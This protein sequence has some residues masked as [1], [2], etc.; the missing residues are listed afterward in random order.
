MKKLLSMIWI[1][2]LFV[3]LIPSVHAAEG[4]VYPI[5][6]DRTYFDG[7]GEYFDEGVDTGIEITGF[8][9]YSGEPDFKYLSEGD[10]IAV[11]SPSALPDRERIETTL[12]GLRAW[13]FEPVEGRYVGGETRTLEE[14]VEDLKWALADPEI[15]AKYAS[16]S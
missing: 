8:K 3:L 6:Y 14:C 7:T 4:T 13:G 12:A 9:R 11:L 2:T 15:K 5:P 1:C 10:K 16:G